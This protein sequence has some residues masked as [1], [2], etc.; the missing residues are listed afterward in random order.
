MIKLSHILREVVEGAKVTF[1]KDN[2][3]TKI[4]ISQQRLDGEQLQTVDGVRKTANCDV[5]YSLESVPDTANIKSAQDALKY[6]SEL[7]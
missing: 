7:S 2:E 6:N 4:E 5:Y 3:P 1:D